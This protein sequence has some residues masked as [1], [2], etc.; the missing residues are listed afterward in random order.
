MIL[1]GLLDP[2][3]EGTMLLQNIGNCT[4]NDTK[5]HPEYTN[6]ATAGM[7]GTRAHIYGTTWHHLSLPAEPQIQ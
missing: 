3:D 2:E 6:M 4:Q 7:S 1:L 5:A